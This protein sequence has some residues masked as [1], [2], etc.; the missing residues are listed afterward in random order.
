MSI[1]NNL[2]SI[3]SVV[4]NYRVYRS[5]SNQF[6]YYLK[7]LS[8]KNVPVSGESEYLKKWSVF[9]PHVE[10]YSYRLFSHFMGTDAHII[11]EDIGHTYIE[12]VLNPLR[13]RDYYSDKNLYDERF[14][15][16]MLPIT[17]IRR[18]G[19]SFLLNVDYGIIENFLEVKDELL[20][21]KYEKLILKPT[22]DSCSGHGVM[23]FE[24]KN[25]EYISK[26]EGVLLSEDFLL[27]YGSDF[28][29]QEALEQSPYMSNFNRTSVNTIRI[30]TYRSVKDESV[31]VTACV[32]RIGKMGE[33]VDNGHS[34][35]NFVGINPNSG[36][37]SSY[38]CDQYGH[39]SDVWNGINF[40]DNHFVIPN[41]EKII[42]FAK[43]IGRKNH[44][45]RLL[46]LDIAI[47]Q[48]GNPKLIEYNVYAFGFWLFMFQGQKPFGT[49]TD[50][51]I[52]YC[53]KRKNNSKKIQI[54]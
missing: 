17:F 2:V 1:K 32:I 51:I 28:I 36:E 6:K 18:M 19:D 35:G 48:D 11:P 46:A 44:H 54:V 45:C 3:M 25:D 9:T 43:Y 12:N 8:I 38:A 52:E 24:R 40:K 7:Q 15:S 50:E 13:Y 30:A 53:L 39:R 20:S 10:P 5:Y 23:L 27:Q 14:I 22:I 42:E 47:A 37:L 49:F 16:G 41:W 4:Q 34:G 21:S 26:K 29:L 31:N 33:I